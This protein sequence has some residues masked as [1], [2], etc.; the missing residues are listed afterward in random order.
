M[1]YKE[2]QYEILLISKAIK[3]LFSEQ[4]VK[5]KTHIFC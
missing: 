5:R 1:S 4:N 2:T 3:I